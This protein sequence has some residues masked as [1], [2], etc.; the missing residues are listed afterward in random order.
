MNWGRSTGPGF[1]RG[2]RTF[3]MDVSSLDLGRE[4]YVPFDPSWGKPMQ[5]DA[6]AEA[7]ER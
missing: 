7:P 5:D 1:M 4:N 2:I 6:P 3:V